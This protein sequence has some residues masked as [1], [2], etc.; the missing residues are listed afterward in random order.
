MR[1]FLIILLLFPFLLF[2]QKGETTVYNLND[3]IKQALR[4]NYEIRMSEAQTSSAEADIKSAFGDFLPS[5]SINSGYTRQLNAQPSF[6]LVESQLVKTDPRANTYSL[7]AGARLTIFDGFSRGN[8]YKRAN[9]TYQSSLFA[10]KHSM[11]KVQLQVYQQY[12]DV[13][14]QYQIVKIRKQNIE[15]G[16]KELERIKAQNKAGLIPIN[17]VLSQEA[18]LGNKEFDLITAENNLNISKATLMTT[19]GL[20][21]R[22][23]VEFLESS[24]PNTINKNEEQNFRKQIGDFKYVVDKSIKNRFDWQARK[25]SVQASE[26]SIA[27]AQASYYPVV[28][29]SGGWNWSNYELSKFSDFGRSSIGLSLYIPI[30]DNFNT[31]A[32][33]QSAK[34]QLEQNKLQQFQLEQNIK[35]SIKI[36]FLNLESSE[37]QLDISERAL[38]SAKANFESAKERF[39]IGS[40]SI[41]DYLTANTQLITAQ[42]NR[43]NAIY[44]YFQSQKEVLYS[45][46]KL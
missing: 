21:P 23:D 22:Y 29:A 35:S 44:K 33:I 26:S 4:N 3:C 39:R 20:M 2:S 25:S 36:A 15:L 6:G 13:I 16:N 14:A 43:V 18:D 24:L 5:I 17:N 27:I 12:I 31:N 32:R 8:N 45:I 19:M 42:I 37:K 10:V 38:K 9:E 40:A 28:S 7:N 1:I 46:G 11:K 34:L 41:T 30:F